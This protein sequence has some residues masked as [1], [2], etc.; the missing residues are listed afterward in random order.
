LVDRRASVDLDLRVRIWHIHHAKHSFHGSIYLWDR[1]SRFHLFMGPSTWV[2]TSCLYFYTW[3]YLSIWFA[4]NLHHNIPAQG[5]SC[6]RP[7]ETH[8]GIQ[9]PFL[10][11]F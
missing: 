11:A 6:F 5:H 2:D 10:I 9:G 7:I 4:I 1:F 3:T 8:I